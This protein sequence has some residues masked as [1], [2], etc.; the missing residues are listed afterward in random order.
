MADKTFFYIYS[1]ADIVLA[2]IEFEDIDIKPH[3]VKIQQFVKKQKADNVRRSL[4]NSVTSVGIS[5]TDE[6]PAYAEA[7]AGEGG[8]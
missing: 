4:L 6:Q 5:T 3:A 8:L 1:A 2:I 7:S